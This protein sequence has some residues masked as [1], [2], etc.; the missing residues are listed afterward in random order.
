[1][2]RDA[3]QLR[4][5]AS[6]VATFAECTHKTALDLAVN[7]G[8]HSPPPFYSDPMAKLLRER[9]IAHEVAYLGTLQQTRAVEE[10]ATEPADAAQRT[11][12]AMRRGV[13]VIYQGTLQSGPW[14]GRPDFLM[15]VAQ[16]RGTWAWSYEPAD[17]KLALTAKA[18]GMLQLCFY[19]E[20]LA[21]LQGVRPERMT[22]VLGDMRE[23]TFV[24]ARYQ[25]YFRLIRRRF[26][27]AVA[28]PSVTYPEPV[29]HCNICDW[30]GECSARRRAD[31][32][33]SL[34]AG[35][36]SSQRRALDLVAIRQVGELAALS[37]SMPV[38]GIGRSALTR[39][40]EQARIQVLG[41]DA[42]THVYELIPD[43]EDGCGLSRL[44]EPSAGD[45][46][47]D[48]EGD[49]F[50][51]D[52]GIEY[53]FGVAARPS[54]ATSQPPYTA[55]WALDATSERVA[56]ER[57]IAIISQR[58]SQHPGMHVYHYAPYERTA[59]ERLA[60]RYATCVDSLDELLRA[61]VFIDLYG[62]MRQAV[63]ASV[64]SYS[65]KR[66]EPLYGFERDVP[67]PVANRNLA[68]FSA[69]L[70]IAHI[71]LKTVGRAAGI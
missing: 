64:E 68:A 42:G 40:R 51:P 57:L 19:A 65:I 16:P 20:L 18:Q 29:E 41:R 13:D 48:L 67:L 1:M 26:E 12:E 70:E 49:S 45:L 55:L 47:V 14:A 50:A 2:K 36:S 31:D 59:F 37:S 58:R 71:D 54:D 8:K 3:E 38:K 60:G 5:T 43:V 7:E 15:R 46:F 56:F 35:I 21:H 66:L 61:K 28:S 44:P 39:V 6:D 22:L 9:G 32:H 10:I 11:L 69:W 24:T 23:E 63:R 25:A 4:F 33:L 27:Q 30:F 17:A 52:G 62:V 53:L 34:V